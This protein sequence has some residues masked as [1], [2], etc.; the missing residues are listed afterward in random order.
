MRT[1]GVIPSARGRAIRLAP[2]FYTTLEEVDRSLDVLA[3]VASVECVRAHPVGGDSA[4]ERYTGRAPVQV[5]E[6]I[7][8]WIHEG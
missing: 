1:R 5:V 8:D 6:Q 3:P 4:D 7:D 2:H